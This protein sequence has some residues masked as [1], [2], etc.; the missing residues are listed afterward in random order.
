MPPAA[1]VS[2]IPLGITPPHAVTGLTLAAKFTSAIRHT[3]ATGLSIH[4]YYFCS[5]ICF[6]ISL[7]SSVRAQHRTCSHRPC[8]VFRCLIRCRPDSNFMNQISRRPQSRP[9]AQHLTESHRPHSLLYHFVQ[10]VGLPPATGLTVPLAVTGLPLPAPFTSAVVLTPA[11]GLSISHAVTGLA[12]SSAV[13]YD[14]ATPIVR[15]GP[16]GGGLDPDAGVSISRAVTRLALSSGVTK[17]AGRTRA[18]RNTLAVE[19]TTATATGLGLSL[20]VTG[21]TGARHVYVF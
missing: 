1:S 15:I 11:R 21:P 14:V 20:S 7:H 3:Q 18:I 4:L 12:L 6:S 9:R 16:A 2:D 13:T 17:A 5:S 19:L 10:V 8:F